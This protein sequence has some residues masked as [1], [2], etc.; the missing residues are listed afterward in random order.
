MRPTSH[1]IEGKTVPETELYVHFAPLMSYIYIYIHSLNTTNTFCVSQ[2]NILLIRN[3]HIE[4]EIAQK[5]LEPN[6]I[7]IIILDLVGGSVEITH[8]SNSAR[9]CVHQKGKTWDW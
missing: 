3:V 9:V 5:N 7:Y 2:K 6:L 1:N 8:R 4:N